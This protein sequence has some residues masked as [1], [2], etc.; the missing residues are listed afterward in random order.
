MEIV[1]GIH[2]VLALLERNP[3][4]V[5]RVLVNKNKVNTRVRELLQQAKKSR[6]KVDQVDADELDLHADG[7]HQ[8]V[9]AI[10]KNQKSL[11]EGDLDALLE[12]ASQP[13]ILVLDGVTDTQNLGAC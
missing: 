7:N 3:G 2:A 13:I 4:R 12:E 1:F 8:G 9:L 11:S 10:C 5:E 6:V